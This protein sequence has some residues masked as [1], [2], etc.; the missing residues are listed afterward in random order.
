MTTFRGTVQRRSI[1]NA[2][3]PTSQ[4]LQLIRKPQD[5]GG[6]P[7]GRAIDLEN[8]I[9]GRKVKNTFAQQIGGNATV[10]SADSHWFPYKL[11][12][13]KLTHGIDHDYAV[14]FPNPTQPHKCYPWDHSHLELC[15]NMNT[16]IENR[17]PALYKVHTADVLV[18][19]ISPSGE[20]YLHDNDANLEKHMSEETGYVHFVLYKEGLR[21]TQ[22]IY[23][24]SIISGLPLTT[25]SWSVGMDAKAATS[26]LVSVQVSGTV[27][28]TLDALARLGTNKVPKGIIKLGSMHY[29]AGAVEPG[30]TKGKR[31][32]ILLRNVRGSSTEVHSKMQELRDKGF[33]NYFGVERFGLTQGP[34]PHEVAVLVLNGK[35]KEAFM[36]ILE[37]EAFMNPAVERILKNLTTVEKL[38]QAMVQKV[39]SH[40]PHVKTLLHG[41]LKHSSF[42]KAYFSVAPSMRQMWETSLSS[43][44]WNKLAS[45]RSALGHDVVVADIVWLKEEARVHQVTEEDV[46]HSRFSKYDIVI[47]VPGIPPEETSKTYYPCLPGCDFNAVMD[48]LE[49]LSVSWPF[50]LAKDHAAIAPV[51]RH[52]FVQHFKLQWEVFQHETVNERVIATDPHAEV[53]GVFCGDVVS[54]NS[55]SVSAQHPLKTKGFA[56]VMYT[57]DWL[58]AE[59]GTRNVFIREKCEECEALKE[60][61]ISQEQRSYQRMLNGDLKNCNSVY[62]TFAIPHASYATV[63]VRDAFD[64]HPW[65]FYPDGYFYQDVIQPLLQF[66]L[67]KRIISL[68]PTKAELAT[69]TWIVEGA[70]SDNWNDGLFSGVFDVPSSR[71]DEW[72][73]RFSHRVGDTSDPSLPHSALWKEEA[74]AWW[75]IDLA[76]PAPPIRQKYV[77]DHNTGGVISVTKQQKQ[78]GRS[79]PPTRFTLPVT[80]LPA[81]VRNTVR[82]TG[83]HT[84]R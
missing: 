13:P 39:P 45:N 47:P 81:S 78:F 60:L 57:F 43:L 23:F 12:M 35:Y 3:D 49:V 55:K 16:G 58:C 80:P 17:I 71:F 18:H 61:S 33:I 72:Y 37:M 32:A 62:L 22:A 65:R 56:G 36:K 63:A 54:C 20:V 46:I 31:V 84:N 6:R 51:Y 50:K 9:K 53:L 25:F 70:K 7:I 5:W 40:L 8:R 76:E 30:S 26:Q 66:H 69:D 64:L 67:D 2:R 73:S 48:A 68:P 10:R 1:F 4:G 77:H 52:V 11:A 19:E 42:K 83:F 29:T 44:I 21:T 74:E 27:Q 34:K 14:S 75:S 41:L 79:V 38:S 15:A 28:R 24:I 59:C 82:T